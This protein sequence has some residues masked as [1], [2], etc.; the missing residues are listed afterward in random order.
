MGVSYMNYKSN[1]Y[2]SN[3]IIF[4]NLHLGENVTILG[5]DTEKHRQA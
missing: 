5:Q 3:Y 2:M 1:V 4:V